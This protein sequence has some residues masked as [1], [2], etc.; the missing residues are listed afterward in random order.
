MG[1][2]PPS[3]P[4]VVEWKVQQGEGSQVDVT[5]VVDGTPFEIGSLD[6]MATYEAGPATCALRAASPRRTELVCGAG[7]AYEASLGEG[8]LVIS[9]LG[10]EQRRVIK[11]VPV[12]GDALAVKMLALPFDDS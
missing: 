6:G 8:E 1:T 7:D 4:I 3:P 12:I 5:F 2:E 9:H 10:G 11:R